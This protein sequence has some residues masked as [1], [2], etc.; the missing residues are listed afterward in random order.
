MSNC[1]GLNPPS[2]SKTVPTS[3][4]N[5]PI[6][7]SNGLSSESVPSDSVIHC[8]SGKLNILLTLFPSLFVYVPTPPQ[9][10]VATL[11]MLYTPFVYVCDIV[12][13]PNVPPVNANFNLELDTL[14]IVLAFQLYP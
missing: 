8:I 3:S 1:F 11:L 10:N 2:L 12:F 5:I 9:K 4:Q 6:N 13:V 7:F 14:G